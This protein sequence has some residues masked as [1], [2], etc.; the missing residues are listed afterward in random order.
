MGWSVSELQ[1]AACKLGWC[2]MFQRTNWV[3]LILLDRLPRSDVGARSDAAD[4]IQPG[5]L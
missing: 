1:D 5:A 3:P 2:G 4:K